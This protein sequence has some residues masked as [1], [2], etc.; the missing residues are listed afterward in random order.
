VQDNPINFAETLTP[1]R[2][3]NTVHYWFGVG[4]TN[5]HEQVYV[6]GHHFV[7]HDLPTVL[8]GDLGDQFVEAAADPP[9]QQPTPILRAPHQMQAQRE[10]ASRRA[11]KPLTR[12]T[13]NLTQR[14]RQ[15]MRDHAVRL[16]PDSPGR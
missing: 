15:N 5:T 3:H 14:H 9:A 16:R 12:H 8:D 7:S 13:A 2:R 10:H 6:I 4:R 1:P 11:T